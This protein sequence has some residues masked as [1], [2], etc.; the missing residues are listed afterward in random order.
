MKK[1]KKPPKISQSKRKELGQKLEQILGKGKVFIDE[2]TRNVYAGSTL[3]PKVTPD[4]VVKPK[5][6]DDVVK[7]L[8]FA[9]EHLIPVTPVSSGSQ[10]SSTTPFWKGIVLDMMQMDRL[11]EID[12]ERGYALIEPGVT[13]GELVKKTAEVGYHVT[14]GSFPP[15]LS[16]L[17]NYTLTN[18]NT[19]RTAMPDD[20][21]ALEVVIPDGTVVRTGSMAFSDYSD[22]MKWNSLYNSYPDLKH[23]FMNAYGTLGVITKAAIRIYPLGEEQ[24]LPL[25][26]FDSYRDA[27]CFMKKASRGYLVKHINT[28]HWV[29]YTLI[30]H[31]ATYGHGGSFDAFLHDPWEPPDERPYNIVIPTMGGYREDMEAHCKILEKLAVE[32][33]GRDVTGYVQEQFPNLYKFWYDH[34]ALHRAD[35]TFMGAY[36][37]GKPL[38]PIVIADPEKVADLEEWGLKRMRNSVLKFGLTYYSHSVDQHRGVFIRFTPFIQ[39]D[40]PP[41]E[42]KEAFDVYQEVMETAIKKYG[43]TPVRNAAFPRFDDPSLS[44]ANKMGG[45]GHLMRL[46]KKALDPWNIMNPGFSYLFYGEEDER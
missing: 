15:G 32:C 43:A 21:V 12:T 14:I 23:L 29:V 6:V 24:P 17:G 18:V 8:D 39:Y 26:G 20:V 10:E 40:T 42:I 22:S 28:W 9:R 1:L 27:L 38:F 34:Y 19:H 25:F 37:E 46:L 31:L 3:S 36:G 33:N 13:V 30:D 7:T 45:F 16:A 4:F 5:D 2:A 44:Y 41:E 11:I 35:T